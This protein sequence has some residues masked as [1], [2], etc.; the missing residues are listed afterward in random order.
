M[1][2]SCFSPPRGF[3]LLEVLVALAVLAIAM[4]ALIKGGADNARGA[5]YLR[6]KTLAQWVAMNVVAE[7]RLA[8]GWPATGTRRGQE[9]MAG[10]EWYWELTVAETFDEDIRRLEVAVRATEEKEA[11]RLVNLV[12]F[13]PR[14]TAASPQPGGAGGGS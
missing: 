10:H 2:R 8:A 6:D 13:L 1:R 11:G 9:E 5:A 4:A 7:Q 3:T 12:A 14:P